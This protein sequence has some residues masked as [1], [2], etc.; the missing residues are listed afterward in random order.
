MDI[1]G[2][3]E[4]LKE[5]GISVGVDGDHIILA[6]ASGVPSDVAQALREHKSQ[7]L[8][9]LKS[10]SAARSITEAPFPEGYFNFPPAQ[11]ELAELINDRFGV[12]DSEHRR[13][14]VLAWARGYYQD[15]EQNHG[16]W[17]EGLIREQQR[18]SRVLAEKG[19]G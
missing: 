1:S 19:I 6:P 3:L 10:Q 8:D 2:L 14:N 11:L 4:H 5:S 18:L 15:R 9:Y 13:Y 17:Y 12:T 7:V 16:D